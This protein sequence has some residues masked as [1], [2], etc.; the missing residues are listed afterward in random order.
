MCT[1]AQTHTHSLCKICGGGGVGSHSTRA[2]RSQ[3]IYHRWSSRCLPFCFLRRREACLSFLLRMEALV[4]LTPVGWA[5]ES[6]VSFAYCE[7]PGR[8]G[9]LLPLAINH[10]QGLP[11]TVLRTSSPCPVSGT[12]CAKCC[13]PLSFT[14]SII[15][16][17][18]PRLGVE[19]EDTSAIGFGSIVFG[20]LEEHGFTRGLTIAIYGQI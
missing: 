17:S 2:G 9:A 8:Y 11:Y 6:L 10:R 14:C 5:L 19:T 3:T 13:A 18:L 20:R 15:Y 12:V 7:P 4:T 1:L 16:S